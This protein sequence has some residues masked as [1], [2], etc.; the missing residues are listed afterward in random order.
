MNRISKTFLVG[1]IVLGFTPIA[2]GISLLKAVQPVEVKA[3]NIQGQGTIESP[4]LATS[5]EDLRELFTN[6]DGFDTGE[7]KRHITLIGNI[8]ESVD[9]NN[10]ALNVAQVVN[11]ESKIVYPHIYLDLNGHRITRS[12]E[13]TD[14]T[15]LTVSSQGNLYI[16]DNVGTGGIWGELT[17]TATFNRLFYVSNGGVLTIN[18]GTYRNNISGE[19]ANS[20]CLDNSG[21]NV[22]V[23]GGTFYSGTRPFISNGTDYIYGGSFNKTSDVSGSV[24]EIQGTRTFADV[25]LDNPTVTSLWAPYS[26]DMSTKYVQNVK[27]IEFTAIKPHFIEKISKSADSM[28]LDVDR[29][30]KALYQ[31]ESIE[32][33]IDCDESFITDNP[34]L[35]AGQG[36]ELFRIQSTLSYADYGH[37]FDN[38]RLHAKIKTG[39]NTVDNNLLEI[40]PNK[41]FNVTFNSNGGAGTMDV[42]E[43][44]DGHSYVLPTCTFTAPAGK[45]FDC[46]KVNE[47]TYAAGES[48][49]VTANTEVVAQWKDTPV[50]YSV[51]VN[52]GT[53]NPVSA[54]EG[55]TITITANAPEEGKVF[56]GWTS[57]DGVAFADASALTTTFVMPSKNVTVTANYENEVI[58]TVLQSITLS[59][60]HKTSFRVGDTFSYEGLVVTA[61]YSN[62]TSHEV[63]TYTVST[64]DLS[65][66]GNKDVTVTYTEDEITKTAVYQIAVVPA[67][68][69]VV[70]ESITLSGT[71]PTEFEVGDEFSYAGLVVTAHYDGKDDA[72]VTEYIVST[73]DMSTA[74]TKEITV[75]YTE[76]GVTKTATYQ[77]TVTNPGGDDSSSSEGGSSSS[78][79]DVTPSTPSKS[80]PAGAIVGIVIGSV[81]V[82]GIGG[83]ALVWFVIKKKSWADFVAL[84]KKK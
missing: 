51:T 41:E 75:S 2:A 79:G 66:T 28:D 4:Y 80:L 82:L 49:T 61:N 31:G 37:K 6:F 38:A 24:I 19:S 72:V 81:L 30:I 35:F 12:C 84:F 32:W 65:T 8:T 40:I 83:F 55:T 33:Y 42:V 50:Q 67:E 21:G 9:R 1:A 5:Y 23:Y 74:G 11:A 36:T 10:Y 53:A 3:F 59:G 14:A 47:T 77:I 13:T 7:A 43:V 29:V 34:T 25:I 73:P 64:P 26:L 62:G 68:T 78:G 69:P 48:I 57:D 39:S 15:F 63:T 27:N 46:W 18:G 60:T 56:S 58:P 16:Q 70:L 17:S 20:R 22:T 52:G 44:E 45:E 54:T 71:Y 76:D